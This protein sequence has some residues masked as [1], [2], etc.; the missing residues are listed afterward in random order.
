MNSIFEESKS[1]LTKSTIILVIGLSIS[2]LSLIPYQ[3]KMILE[4]NKFEVK[5][6]SNN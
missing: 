4:Y 2:F 1:N 6:D 5:K 3:R